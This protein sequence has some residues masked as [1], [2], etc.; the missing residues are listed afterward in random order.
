MSGNKFPEGWDEAKIQSVLKHY[1]QQTDEEAV[2]EDEAA[3]EVAETVMTVP[4]MTS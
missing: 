1:E 2:L 3:F 4:L